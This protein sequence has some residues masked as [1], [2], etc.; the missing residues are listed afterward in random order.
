MALIIDVA[1]AIVKELNDHRFSADFIAERRYLPILELKEMGELHVTV[2][3][4]GVIASVISKDGTA[5]RDLQIQ[6]AIQKKLLKIEEDGEVDELMG[7][8]EEIIAHLASIE[9]FGGAWCR[10]IEN[11]PTYQ[12]EDLSTLRQFTSV[13]VLSLKI[14]S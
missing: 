11:S 6:I 3:M 1:D 13:I 12:R 10:M 7:L 5:D 14:A 8:A 9:T 4:Q 2:L